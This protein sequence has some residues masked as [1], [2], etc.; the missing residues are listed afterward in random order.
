MAAL[1]SVL[2]AEKQKSLD[3]S[4]TKGSGTPAESSSSP[5]NNS[6]S[7]FLYRLITISIGLALCSSLLLALNMTW[8]NSLFYVPI[9]L[10]VSLSKTYTV[11][12][13]EPKDESS[14]SETESSIEVSQPSETEGNDSEP[15]QESEQDENDNGGSGAI[16]TYEQLRAKSDNPVTGIDFKRRE[17]S[18]Y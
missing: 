7:A 16:F 2:S 11:C 5:G 13:A 10:L 9:L 6:Q 18:C 14:F 4:P 12:A 1:S 15:K 3:T 8:P 17:V